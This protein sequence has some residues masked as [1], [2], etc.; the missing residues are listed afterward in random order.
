[1]RIVEGHF[2]LNY[3]CLSKAI[4]MRFLVYFLAI[5]NLGSGLHGMEMEPE[6]TTLISSDGKRFIVPKEI[7]E[8]AEAYKDQIQKSGDTHLN[9]PS[10]VLGEVVQLMQMLYQNKNLAYYQLIDKAEKEIPIKNNYLFAAAVR[11]LDFKP[12][13][14]LISFKYKK[15]GDYSLPEDIYEHYMKLIGEL[16][17]Q[18]YEKLRACEKAIGKPCIDIGVSKEAYPISPGDDQTEGYPIIQIDPSLEFRGEMGTM[19]ELSM[20]LDP[21]L[22]SPVILP[23]AERSVALEIIKDIAPDLY[24]LL[25]SVDPSGIKHF[26]SDRVGPNNIGVGVG[27]E[28]FP[29]FAIGSE[30]FQSHPKD[31]LKYA[32]AHELG[33]YVRGHPK[34]SIKEHKKSL[35]IKEPESFEEYKKSL[36]PEALQRIAMQE[37]KKGK[38]ISGQ[39]PFEETFGHAY[40]RIQEFEADRFAVIDLGQSIDAGIAFDESVSA[41][42]KE[43][44]IKTPEKA[45]FL[46]TH[47]LMRAR[48]QQLKDLRRE[49][50]LNKERGIKSKQKINWKELAAEYLKQSQEKSGANI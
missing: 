1:M 26:F 31:Q 12:G 6:A 5:L 21:Y 4:I 37:F 50:E 29:V 9:I 44:E 42:A 41:L 11:F 27:Q 8:Q 34:K 20:Y 24:D 3:Q 15:T 22:A 17:P 48:I 2:M 49:V 33:H 19:F 25:V 46:M 13:I 16:N 40:S 30:L 45:T 38:K 23:E 32:F 35:K 7:A 18:A 14:D 36:K 39:L 28:G 43:H 47:P 10:D